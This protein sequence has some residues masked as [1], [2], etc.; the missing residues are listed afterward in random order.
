[1]NYFSVTYFAK[2]WE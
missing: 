1:M 2:C